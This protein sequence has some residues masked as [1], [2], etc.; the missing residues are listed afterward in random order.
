LYPACCQSKN[1][2]LVQTRLSPPELFTGISSTAIGS[3][4]DT[5][6]DLRN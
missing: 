5:L 2:A 1:K 3:S 6:N 4:P